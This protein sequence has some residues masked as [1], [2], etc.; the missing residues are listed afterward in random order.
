MKIR[1]SFQGWIFGGCFL[2][3]LCTLIFVGIIVQHS[4]HERLMQ[5]IREDMRTHLA[6]AS[7][8]V[9]DRLPRPGD[10][11][12]A[13]AL[14]GDLGKR[15]HLR[16][17][18]I[19]KDGVVLGDSKVP[20]KELPA[21][22]N[23]ASRPEV[24][25]AMAA[26]T[27][28]S[29]RHS[30]TL[31]LDL[32]Y[33]AGKQKLQDG[34][35]LVVRLA[36]PLATIARGMDD[37]RHLIVVAILLGLMLST[38]VAY[39]VARGISRPVK[40]LTRTATAIAG[41]DLS[42]RFRRYPR[43]EVGELGRAFDQMAESL[44]KEIEA[45]RLARDRRAAILSAMRE[46]VLV[47]D[48]EGGILLTNQAL[49][50]LLGLAEDPEGRPA[51]ETIRNAD[52]L[53]AMAAVRAG[54]PHVVAEMR[55]LGPERRILGINAVRITG[56]DPAGGCVAVLHDVTEQKR[57]EQ[58]RRDFVANVSH[59]L[60]TPLTAIRGSVDTLLGGALDSPP[61]AKRFCE[62]IA[63]QVVRLD[64]L[65]KD[66][67]DLAAIE[68]GEGERRGEEITAAELAESM[69]ATVSDLAKTRQVELRTELPE[70]G[71]SFRGDRRA[72]EQAALNL[73]DNAVKYT[74]SGGRVTLSIVREGDMVRIDV[75]DTGM[76]IAPDQQSRIFERFYRVDK[77][78]SR[79]LGGTGLGL[80]IVKHTAKALGGRV[81]L[82]SAPG[83]G[84]TF[85]LLIPA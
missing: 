41:G 50:N 52:L 53:E 84:S 64:Q 47:T 51:A 60:R 39:L 65:V 18:L 75:A 36:L 20:L 42:R 6:L 12:L 78:R 57:T 81:E 28:S 24:K 33:V 68:S 70:G 19:R 8:I 37:V 72:L 32:L 85:S 3:V 69:L 63:R 38:G 35:T 58:V 44:Q 82:Q 9:R 10:P 16:V 77:N 45:V 80:A 21:L 55:T 67:L 2:V 56:E 30:S 76:G 15:L 17:T 54:Q 27:G 5:S 22:E 23:H 74:P 46:G 61:D 83:K 43:H 79:E 29:V 71:L 62:M 4:V 34:D 48:A 31:G 49:R 7:E 1:L 73:L 14:A 66:I 11:A 40:E 13:D 25:R 26:G 59:E